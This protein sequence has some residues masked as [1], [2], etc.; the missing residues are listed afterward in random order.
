MRRAAAEGFINATDMADYLVAK[1]LPFRAAY[2]I[3]GTIVAYCI[4]ERKTLETLSP[5]EYR[6]FSELFGDDIYEAVSLDRCLAQR[7]SFGGTAP[8][9]V[10]AQIEAVRAEL[11][12]MQ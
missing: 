10:K 7:R 8:E 5:E 2:K 6:S 3:S 9:C 1:G 4:K 12:E 11:K